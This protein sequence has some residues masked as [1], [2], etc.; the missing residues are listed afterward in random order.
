MIIIDEQH[1]FGA[2]Q[3]LALQQK[4]PA[5]DFL[6]MSATPIPQTLAKTLYGDLDLVTIRNRPGHRYPVATHF[7]PENKRI[8]M[9]Q[10]VLAQIQDGSQVFYI[11][12]RIEHD[13]D[14]EN[15]AIKDITTVFSSLLYGTF[16]S[17][18]MAQLHGK[19][20]NDEK[21]L[22]MQDFANGSTKLLVA[23]SIVEVGI[24]IPNATII[25]IENAE[26]FGLAQLH[27]LR[28]R[29]GRGNKK[30]FCFLLL[31]EHSDTDTV[32][33]ISLFC[34]CQD[35]FEIAEMDLQLR[36]PGEVIGFKQSGWEDLIMADIVKDAHLF[37][38]IQSEIDSIIVN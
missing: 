16:S 10:F 38:E 33:R 28:G 21:E 30:S 26:R 18:S 22:I 20:G 14:T 6:L 8:D 11:V 5:S 27:Q 3:R 15:T 36:G 4:D 37:K 9:E 19:M 13:E 35:G 17:I 1:K 12:P 2:D 32:E 34:K 24:D 7:V 23:T 29:V 31:S 25:I